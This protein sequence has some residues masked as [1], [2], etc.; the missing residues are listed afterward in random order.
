M[1]DPVLVNFIQKVPLYLREGPWTLAAHIYLV[2]FM[3]FLLLTFPY[4]LRSY[5]STSSSSSHFKREEES[6]SGFVGYYRGLG[7][8][9][10]LSIC[11][12]V[13]IKV[14]LWPFI[15]YTITSWNLLTLRLVSSSLQNYSSLFRAISRFLRFPAL[16]GT[17]VT[18]TIWWLVLF[19]LIYTAS[20][21]AHRKQFL[22]FNAS[23]LLINIHLLNMPIC[24]ME[25]LLSGVRLTYFDLY[26]G[27]VVALAYMLFYL[28]V[29]DPRGVHLYIILTP[30]TSFCVVNYSLVLLVYVACY[31]GWNAVLT[32]T[33]Q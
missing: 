23:F 21:T 32:S 20:D 19:P 1:A 17:T 4:A 7:A 16:A 26:I 6:R 13:Y 5:S 18:F 8:L 3:I 22:E 15:T 25:F 24:A 9:Y 31:Y 14:G 28:N 30:R 12:Y 29:L 10:C 27:F 33:P 2:Y 11:M